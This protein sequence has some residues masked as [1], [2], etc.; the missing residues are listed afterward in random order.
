MSK[1]MATELL[2]QTHSR[3]LLADANQ[4]RNFG[5]ASGVAGLV[6]GVAAGLFAPPVGVGVGLVGAVLAAR[7]LFNAEAIEKRARVTTTGAQLKIQKIKIQKKRAGTSS[8]H[9]HR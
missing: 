9:K 6:G 3:Q 4:Q 7:M 5:T 1:I 8:S 2:T